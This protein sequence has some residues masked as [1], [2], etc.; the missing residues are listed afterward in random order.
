MVRS[1]CAPIS[2]HDTKPECDTPRA[3]TEANHH[4]T[5]SCKSP[6]LKRFHP[7]VRVQFICRFQSR[8]AS[9]MTV[10]SCLVYCCKRSKTGYSTTGGK[11][12]CRMS[13]GFNVVVMICVPLRWCIAP[14][15]SYG[16]FSINQRVNYNSERAP[17]QQFRKLR[18]VSCGA[19]QNHKL[20]QLI[21]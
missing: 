12:H 4:E 9:C 11:G 1:V 15:M 17:N 2:T 18:L 19:I 20:Q 3:A 8:S 13:V 5:T 16:S 21:D 7:Y 6:A 10:P 14:L